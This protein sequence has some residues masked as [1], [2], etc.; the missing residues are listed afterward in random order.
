MLSLI[1]NICSICFI[2]VY[3]VTLTGRL[4]GFDVKED[5]IILLLGF[6]AGIQA[7]VIDIKDTVKG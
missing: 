4:T 5:D 6:I 3:I 2:I 7:D 1:L